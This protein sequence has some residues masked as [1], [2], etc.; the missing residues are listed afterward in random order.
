MSA[1]SVPLGDEATR[2]LAQSEFRSPLVVEAGAGTGKT[3]LLVAR[4]AAWCVGAGWELRRSDDGGDE[5]TARR[6]IEGVVAITFTEAAAAEMATRIG[7]AL[8]GLANGDEPV[9]WVAG[10]VVAGV[11]DGEL[12]SRARALVDEVH[13]LGVTTIHA[14]CQRTLAAHPFEA[15]LHP[16]FEI[17]ADGAVVE[18]LVDEVV[19][20]ALRELDLHRGSADWERLA[21]AGVG[22]ARIAEALRDL[23][24]AGARSA[25]LA[26]DPFDD[27]AAAAAVESVRRPLRDLLALEAGR[28]AGLKGVKVAVETVDVL[29]TMSR[30]VAGDVGFAELAAAITLLDRSGRDRLRSWSKGTFGKKEAVALADDAERF[31]ELSG[32]L[33]DRLAAVKGLDPESF[34][35]ARRLLHGLL[36]EVDRRRDQRG[37]ATFQD[38]LERTAR[39]FEEHEGIC[40]STRRTIDQLLVD[41]FQDTDD[42][43]CR[44]VRSLALAGPPDERPGLFVV[45]DPKQSIYA[46]RSADLAAY[47]AFVDEVETAGGS[48]RPLTRN[49]RSVKPILDEVERVVA[50]VMHRERGFQPAFEPLEA[51]GDR[52]ASPGFD[53]RPWSAVE[54]WL[55]WRAGDDGAIDPS[56]QRSDDMTALEAATVAADIRRLHDEADVRF[57]DVAVL[58]RSTTRQNQILEAL[59]ELDVPFDVTREREYYRQREIV[60]AA[61]LVRAVLEPADALALLTVIRSDAVGVPDAALA[62]L[63]DAGLPAAVAELDGSDPEA[64][65]TARRIVG[66]A[67]VRAGLPGLD[68]VPRWRDAL[69]AAVDAL[70]EL[71]RS[72]RDDPP[73]VFVERLRTVWLAEV[74]AGAR[75]LGRFRQARLDGFFADLERSLVRG[76]GAAELARFLR[77]SVEE[78]REAPT[79]SEPDRAADAV[80]IMTIYGAKGLDFGHVYLV[81]THRGTGS[82]RGSAAVLRRVGGAVELE[83][84]GWPSPGFGAAEQRRERQARAEAVRLLYVAMTR[85]KQRLVISGGWP[86]PGAEVDP[87]DARS[88]IDLVAHR[89]DPAVIGGL[90]ERGLDREADRAPGVTW[91]M[92]ALADHSVLP[93]AGGSG[94]AAPSVAV[95]A[96]ADDATIIADARAEAETRMAHRWTAPASDAAL[97]SHGRREAEPEADEASA[98]ARLRR[99]GAAVVG[100][101]VHRL[102]ETVAL[103]RDL[104]G[105]IESAR[106]RLAEDIGSELGPDEGGRAVDR[107]G[108]LLDV[109]STGR[110]LTRLAELASSVVVRELDVVARP[111]ADDGTSVVS[112]AVDL[113]YTDPGD[114]RLVVADYKTDAVGTEDEIAERCERYRPQLE[115]YGRALREALD[116]DEEP[117]LELWFLR[118]DQIVRLR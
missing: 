91:V 16:R 77:R 94:R 99:S 43:Q 117:H 9:G 28:L 19:L 106:A 46:W 17:D 41:E 26:S 58:I 73:D 69:T 103:D 78:E 98:P 1:A 105:Q 76:G 95:D 60:E 63:W 97:R 4:V 67:P 42:V 5:E 21:R 57:G 53:Q 3:A 101:A 86:R 65:E 88:L 31:C 111:P 27:R 55:C 90:L 66:N 74:G 71:R 12:E 82:N 24:A 114:G 100:T 34:S 83:L 30:R 87:L 79:A 115:T 84:F 89:G 6:V 72:I 68:L 35:A 112:G 39:L 11:E 116:L 52:A 23:V 48:T 7:E 109:I 80:H 92:P 40:R 20:E 37:I 38:L 113:V 93:A 108:A 81:Q 32:Q 62:P 14:F 64:L 75:H 25:D 56:D 102:L 54:H 33:F 29:S 51:T 8:S 61:A 107:L 15:G 45:G 59:R 36:A 85:A 50:P 49:F 44:I 104:G 10:E 22:P 18:A 70:A 96:V 118:P 47:D 110:C 2:A 13:R